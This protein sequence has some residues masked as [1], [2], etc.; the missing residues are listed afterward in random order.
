MHRAPVWFCVCV[1]DCYCSGER[2]LN[3]VFL[4]TKILFV[5][6]HLQIDGVTLDNFGCVYLT[7]AHMCNEPVVFAF[8]KERG[9][10]GFSLILE[11]YIW[12][13]QLIVFRK[14]IENGSVLPHMMV[15]EHWQ[16]TFV[17][18]SRKGEGGGLN[19]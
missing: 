17:T 5:Q 10:S 16:K 19:L 13:R 9:C 11:P 7:E 6:N 18:I 12:L 2:N 14:N 3:K 15:R 4:A 1:T 8:G